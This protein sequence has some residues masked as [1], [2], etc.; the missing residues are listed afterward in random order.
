MLT[1][2]KAFSKCLIGKANIGGLTILP[3]RSFGKFDF[4]V[5]KKLYPKLE[6]NFYKDELYIPPKIDSEVGIRQVR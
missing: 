2:T 4:T 6:V 5:Y 3:A 1:I